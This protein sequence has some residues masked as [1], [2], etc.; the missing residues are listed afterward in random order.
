[1]DCRQDVWYRVRI[2]PFTDAG[3]LQEMRARLVE[4]E[5]DFMLLRIKNDDA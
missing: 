3:E 2:G 5:L 1:M 4:H